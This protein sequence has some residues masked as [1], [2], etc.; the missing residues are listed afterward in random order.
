MENTSKSMASETSRLKMPK[1]FLKTSRLDP[2]NDYEV[3]L[4]N[5]DLIA[6]WQHLYFA[7]INALMA[8]KTKRNISK[9]LAVETVLYASAQRQIKKGMDLIGIKPDTTNIAIMII[10]ENKESIKTGLSAVSKQIGAKADETVLELSE[11]KN[12]NIQNSFRYFKR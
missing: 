8:L 6:T 4:Y 1:T 11:T 12:R 2:A 5:A 3:Q 7:A 9:T 10:S